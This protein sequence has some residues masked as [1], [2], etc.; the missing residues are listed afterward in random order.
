MKKIIA[1][2]LLLLSFTSIAQT[3]KTLLWEI[4]GNGLTKKSYIYGTMHVNE[5]ISYHL[6]DA[7][8]KHLLEADIVSNESNPESWEVLFELLTNEEREESNKLYNRFNLTPIQKTALYSV[9]SN[10]NIYNTMTSG[11]NSEQ[12]DFQENTVLDM[13]IHQTGKK[14]NKKVTGL[15]DAK[16]SFLKIMKMQN[17]VDEPKEEDRLALMKILKNRNFQTVS[18]DFYREK[19][20]VMLDSIYK[21]IYPKKQHNILITERNVTMANSIE[22]IAKTGSLFAAIGAAHLAGKEGVLQLLAKKGYT[23]KPIIDV[24]TPVGEKQKKTIEEFFPAPILTSFSTKDGMIKMPL[25]KNPRTIEETTACIDLTNGGSI[26]IKRLPLNYFLKKKEDTFNPKTLDSLFFENIPGTI[27][28]KKFFETENYKGYDVKNKTKS[29]N[30]QRYKFYITPLEIIA[31]SM[32]GT[33]DYVRQNENQ[34]FDKIE[35]RNLQ[36]TWDDFKPLKGG[37]AVKIPSYSVIHGNEVDKINNDI[38][39]QSYDKNENAYY[40]LT[41][42]S[43]D[44]TSELENTAFEHKQLQAEF[45]MQNELDAVEHD[46]AKNESS[47]KVGEKNIRLKTFIKGNKYFL[48]GTVNASDKNT[49]SYFKSFAFTIANREVSTKIYNDTINN[50]KVEIPEKINQKIFLNL[51]DYEFKTKNSFLSKNKFYTFY[52]DSGKQIKLEYNKFH[53]YESFQNVDSLKNFFFRSYSKDFKT[54]NEI[55]RQFDDY[56]IA[57]DEDYEEEYDYNPN[58]LSLSNLSNKKGF[59][60]SQWDYLLLK[61]DD[62]YEFITKSYVYNKENNTHVFEAIVTK[63]NATQAV[64]YKTIVKGTAY[65]E[66]QTLVEKDYK[67]SNNFIEKTFNTLEVTAKDSISMFA[68]KFD[69]FLK[70][71]YSKKDTVRFSAIESIEELKIADKDFD[72]VTNFIDTFKFKESEKESITTL[73][74]GI[75]ALKN[76]K[77]IPYLEKKYKDEKT[78]TNTQIAILKA[79]TA[80]KSKI[81]YQKIIELLEYD[82]PI[83]DRQSDIKSLYA[84]FDYDLENSKELFPKIFQFY[85]IKEY[86][87]PTLKLCNALFDK[88]LISPKKIS[89]FKKMV[90]TNAKL[91][92]KRVVSWKEKNSTTDEPMAISEIQLDAV[93]D[94]TAVSFDEDDQDFTVE[95]SSAPVEDLINYIDLLYAFQS[96]KDTDALFGKIKALDIPELN[97]ELLRLGIINDKITKE[98]IRA[99]LEDEKTKFPTI[100]LLQYKDKFNLLATITDKEIVESA[101]LNFENLKTKDS[102]NFIEKRIE[103]KNNKEISL[104]FYK[105]EKKKSYQKFKNTYVYTIA[106]ISEKGKINPTAYKVINKKKIE[107]DDDVKKTIDGITNKTLNE[108]HKRATF[109]KDSNGERF[110]RYDY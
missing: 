16:E 50:F 78:K 72:A 32:N 54:I 52:S 106:F 110:N 83:T 67:N 57:V 51:D 96:D 48:L 84:L 98:E 44:N 107:D 99:T 88:N 70:D 15:E 76:A 2:F 81:A 43:Y 77:V 86:N 3:E 12:A 22:S 33:G 23:V 58:L 41:E 87:K 104:F 45:Y 36:T 38:S 5:K 9:F 59:T 49:D 68:D 6:S 89:S 27:A 30:S 79:L 109:Q 80:Q 71:V 55:T 102:I 69:L 21:L 90:L 61:T 93:V 56:D 34:I 53:K 103:T 105:F 92:Y 17:D 39:I 66:L 101:I 25:F 24:L 20:I 1:A 29:G 10:V 63:P 73:L 4:S 82:L 11:N 60:D 31:I 14:Y 46:I 42:K 91:E 64:K 95:D 108:E 37:F 94:S 65:Y 26:N 100:Q 97:I 7:F 19:D 40:F 74:M 18:N 13:F 8:Y 47:S 28:D 35:I 75:G 85:S 62:K